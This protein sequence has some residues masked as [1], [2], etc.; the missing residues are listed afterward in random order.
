M[1]WRRSSHLNGDGTLNGLT[2]ELSSQWRRS[3]QW[4]GDGALISTARNSQWIDDEA[5][6]STVTKLSTI[7]NRALISM[8][9]ELSSQ[10]RRSSQQIGIG[11]GALNGFF[12]GG[13][14]ELSDTT[15]SW[16]LK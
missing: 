8:A 13:R 4:I 7:G 2:T 10:R 12:F 6:I 11:D 15:V 5:L 1:D 9:T 14:Y 3:S 16:V